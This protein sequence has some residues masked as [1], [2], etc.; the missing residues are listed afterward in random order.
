MSKHHPYGPYLFQGFIK[1]PRSLH[2][3]IQAFTSL[4]VV[5]KRKKTFLYMSFALFQSQ[6]RNVNQPPSQRW[7]LD[8]KVMG[9]R[10]QVV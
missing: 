3:Q 7:E 4:Y 5:P 6:K 9:N 1:A 2:R 10:R 8:L